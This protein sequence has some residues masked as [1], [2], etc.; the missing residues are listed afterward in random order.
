VVLEELVLV[1]KGFR[2]QIQFGAAQTR[3]VLSCINER[4]YFGEVLI[5]PTTFSHSNGEVLLQGDSWDFA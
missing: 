1:E 5:L 3:S 4:Y 2:R